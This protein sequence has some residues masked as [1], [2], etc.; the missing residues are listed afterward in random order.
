MDPQNAE[1]IETRLP[2]ENWTVNQL[3]WLQW[4]YGKFVP[5]NVVTPKNRLSGS[6]KELE[7]NVA[8]TQNGKK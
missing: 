4:K 6:E 2:F 3:I 7:E 5:S 1:M 8:N